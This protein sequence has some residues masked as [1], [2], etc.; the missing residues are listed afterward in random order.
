[1]SFH[2]HI[3]KAAER[4]L[5]G[6]V[7]YIDLVLLNPRAADDLLADVEIKLNGLADFPE[8]YAIVN[9][10]VLHDWD[11]RYIPIQN[12][13]AFYKVVKE[14]KMIYFLR[15]LYGKRDWAAILSQGFSLE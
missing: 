9:D 14:E 3:T 5:E 13:F 10:P 11:I 7:N 15:F 8:Q 4:D 12:Y 6:A 2:I 1:M